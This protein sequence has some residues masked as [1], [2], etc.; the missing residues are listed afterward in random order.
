MCFCNECFW[1]IKEETIF[2][3]KVEDNN[4]RKARYDNTEAPDAAI[5]APTND[6]EDLNFGILLEVQQSGRDKSED[7]SKTSPPKASLEFKIS[8]GSKFPLFLC[9]GNGAVRI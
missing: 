7:G 6:S 5:S 2:L 1:Q 9:P 4:R 3:P 8:D